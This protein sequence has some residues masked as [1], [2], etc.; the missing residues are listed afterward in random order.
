MSPVSSYSDSSRLLVIL[1]VAVLAGWKAAAAQPASD[2]AR[3]IEVTAE[4]FRFVPSWIE[5]VEGETVTLRIRSVDVVH[6]IAIPG[7]GVSERVEPGPPVDVEFVADTP[8]QYPFDCSIMCGAGHAT[9]TGVIT[10]LSRSDPDAPHPSRQADL[11][12]DVVEPDFALVSLPTTRTLPSGSFAFRLAHRFSRPLDGGPAYGNL[13][14]DFFGLDSP[15]LIGLELRY[16]LAPR[17]QV[18]VH[19]NNTRNIQIFGKYHVFSSRSHDAAAVDAFVSVEG[20]D[21]FREHYSTTVG[22]IVSRRFGN[23]LAVYGQP[24]WT[25]NS[26]KPG[27]LHPRSTPFNTTAEDTF[28]LG[29]GIRVRVLDTVAV[30]GEFLPRLAGFDQGEEYAAFAIEKVLGGHLFQL[31]VSNSIGVTPAQLAQGASRSWFLG[32]NIARRLY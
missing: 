15:A 31:N 23:R 30:T 10:V 6:G 27:L 9:M 4:Q 32:F 18:G 17:L 7:L 2:T 19:R 13:L 29:V 24:M 21:N 14:E 12:S 22:G 16:G 8:G 1:L 20:L 26:N 5:V 25:A 3:T 28:A 11:V